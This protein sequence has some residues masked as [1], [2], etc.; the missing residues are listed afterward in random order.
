MA[1][2]GLDHDE[3]PVYQMQRL[4]RYRQVVE[5][6]I[7]AGTAYRCWC[8]P[9][10]LETM[11]E[12]Q[13]ARGEKTHY[14][15][16]WRPAPGKTL[17]APPADVKPVV[18][19]A[20]PPSGSVSWNDLVKGP[21]SIHNEEID[22]LIILRA[23]G[24]P[25]Y[26]F[27]V[28]VDDWD[29]AITHVFRGDEHINKQPWQDHI[30]RALGRRSRCSA[31]VPSSSATTASAQQARGA[32]SVTAYRDAGYLRGDAQLPGANGLEPRRTKNCSAAT[33]WCSGS[34]AA[35]CRKPGAVGPPQAGRVNAHYIKLPTTRGL[36]A[37]AAAAGRRRRGP[38]DLELLARGC[39]LFKDRCST[40]ADLP[41]AQDA[42]SSRCSRLQ[43]TYP[44][45]SV[46]R[47]GRRCGIW[48]AGSP[49]PWDKAGIRRRAE[50]HPGRTR[51]EAAAVAPAVRV[52]VC[53]RAQ[54]LRSTQFC[55]LFPRPVVVSRLRA[56]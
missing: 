40:V 55:A 32:V 12:T 37:C 20:N 13:R 46:K 17:P 42:V 39:A 29:M 41:V 44:H 43:T 2:L 5:Q 24:V 33:N 1:W 25:T 35:T 23:D 36:P 15:G 47:S 18:R 34:T 45:M 8:L 16:R 49:T 48:P 10:E 52:L 22:D 54:P 14:D 28:V 6:M 38:D 53:G 11:R 30:F 4:D 26:N 7:G 19:F 31:T 9:T 3:G 51:A 56:A 27:A 50:G 21:I